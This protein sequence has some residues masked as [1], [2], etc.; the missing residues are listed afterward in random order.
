MLREEYGA[1]LPIL[2]FSKDRAEA[3]DRAAG[4]LLRAEGG[5]IVA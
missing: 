4:L 5:A 3:H 1:E 2:L